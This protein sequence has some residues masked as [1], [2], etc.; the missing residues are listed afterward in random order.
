MPKRAN[1]LCCD[2]LAKEM[3]L[4]CTKAGNGEVGALVRYNACQFINRWNISTHNQPGGKDWAN[5]DGVLTRRQELGRWDDS[6]CAF[7][8]P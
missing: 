7:G 5:E 4:R 6:P 1:R 8:L 2:S 3:H